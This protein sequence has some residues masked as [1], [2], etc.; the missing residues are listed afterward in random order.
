LLITSIVVALTIYTRVGDRRQVLMTTRDVLAGEQLTANDVR[1][2]AIASDDAFRAV[3]AGE[4]VTVVGK[5]AKVRM[6]S[7][8]LLAAESL[9][10]RPLVDPTKALVTVLV[11]AGSTPVGLREG[12]R[13]LLTVVPA[14]S[15]S[16]DPVTVEGFA[17][18]L[19][20]ATANGASTMS[21]SVEV[22]V[23]AASAVGT[24]SKVAISV[25]DPSAVL[26]EGTI[27]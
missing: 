12:S 6:L 20:T 22:P 5:Y 15:G 21:L 16:G 4:R 19:P 2:V 27:A 14:Q 1:V 9:Q 7:G 10:D 13:L 23:V 18:T 3:P 17:T 25:L 8:T 26:P 24:A 11:P